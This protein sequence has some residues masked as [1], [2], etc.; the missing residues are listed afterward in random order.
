MTL[1]SELIETIDSLYR[2]GLSKI[3]RKALMKCFYPGKKWNQLPWTID[4]YRRYL[5][6]A[7]YLS[8]IKPG[9]YK[10]LKSP[11]GKTLFKVKFEAY[12]VSIINEILSKQKRLKELFDF[13]DKINEIN[14]CEYYLENIINNHNNNTNRTHFYIK[15]WAESLR[16]KEI[17]EVKDCIGINI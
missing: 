6:K 10:I 17:N 2:C 12:P 13:K 9:I 11:I 15:R 7:G 14:R 16:N 5:T 4:N 8:T 3:T 1:W